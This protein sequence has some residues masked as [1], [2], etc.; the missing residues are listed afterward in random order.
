MCAP[1]EHHGYCLRIGRASVGAGKGTRPPP[2]LAA[3]LLATAATKLIGRP[4]KLGG[5]AV[6]P[7]DVMCC[8]SVAN[9]AQ[10]DCQLSQHTDQ[11][12]GGSMGAIGGVF[13]TIPRA[14]PAT[15]SL[16][17][18]PAFAWCVAKAA[19]GNSVTLPR[20]RRCCHC[21]C[22]RRRRRKPVAPPPV[23]SLARPH[24]DASFPCAWRRWR[25]RWLLG[26]TS[27]ATGPP[28]PPHPT[29]SPPRR[30]QWLSVDRWWCP[31]LS[32]SALR[33]SRSSW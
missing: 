10:R 27:A 23:L 1:L 3:R 18:T 20:R 19:A 21:R 12:P 13:N 8:A 4:H 15:S 29:T 25:H 5:S 22:C 16:A 32:R 11:Q 2:Q 9:G 7:P 33:R 31:H 26:R 28:N 30:R 24:S 6:S 14:D 17:G